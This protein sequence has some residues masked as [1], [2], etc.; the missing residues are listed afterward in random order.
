LRRNCLLNHITEGKVES[1]DR[2]G[3]RPKLLLDGLRG[4]KMYCNLGEE[5]LDRNVG[6]TR[7]G[8][9]CGPV[10]RQEYAMNDV[11]GTHTQSV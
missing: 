3:R 11:R 6:R 10:A 9:V 1:T 8:R 5:A 4:K 7:F 2:R